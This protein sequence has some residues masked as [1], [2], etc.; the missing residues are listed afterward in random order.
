MTIAGFYL[1]PEG[2][3]LGADSTSSFPTESGMHYLDFAQKIFEIGEAGT[4][5]LMT[6]GLGGLGSK[7]Y[8]TLSAELNDAFA[9]KPPVSI[10]D[11]SQRWLDMIWPLYQSLPL[12]GVFQALRAK[13]PYSSGASGSRTEKEEREFLSLRT[14]LVV[15][16]CIAGHAPPDRTPYAC[17][18]TFEPES[19]P[20]KPIL[21]TASSEGFQWWG[22]PNMVARL[23]FGSDPNLKA[24]ILDS[25]HWSGTQADLDQ[26]LASQQLVHAS[27]PI[28]DA[29]DYV[30]SC[31][32]STIKAMKF[33][34]LAQVCGGPIEI[35]VITTDRKFRWVR[36]KPW[37]AAIIDG[38]LDV[39]AGHTS[40]AR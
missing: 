18:M 27:L 17:S 6:W 12:H 8:R 25:P 22:V 26:L 34:S 28:R 23:V 21:R 14:G 11:A 15:G 36:H 4:M 9:A 37:D 39:R 3:V 13:P 19:L 10:A 20:A 7:S 32:Y 29:I 33:S 5:A 1:S 31:I 30:H 35:A 40:R 2:V 38:E 16:F 24:A